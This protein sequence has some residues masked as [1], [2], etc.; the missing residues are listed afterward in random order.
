MGEFGHWLALGC[1]NNYQR[2]AGHLV[3]EVSNLGE[4]AI[5]ADQGGIRMG[6]KAE[7][8]SEVLRSFLPVTFNCQNVPEI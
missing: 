3:L 7:A 4:A 2:T 5:P 1:K 8:Q 6:K